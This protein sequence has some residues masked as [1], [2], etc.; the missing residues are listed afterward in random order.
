MRGVLVTPSAVCS[1]EIF[2]KLSQAPVAQLDSAS[3]F[4]T[5]GCR[6]ESYRVYFTKV[7]SAELL[8]RL[9]SSRAAAP[10]Q[11]TEAILEAMAHTL[12]F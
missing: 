10:A 5:E 7:N 1:F 8:I 12:E 3:V 9:C 4:G 6:F 2:G 11:R